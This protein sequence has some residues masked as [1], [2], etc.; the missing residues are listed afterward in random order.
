MPAIRYRREQGGM[1]TLSEKSHQEASEGRGDEYTRVQGDRTPDKGR[2][3]VVHQMG[4]EE[5]TV[6]GE[7]T[8]SRQDGATENQLYTERA[9]RGL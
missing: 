5:I 9:E 2:K 1:E 3:A 4:R 7:A 8:V 6:H